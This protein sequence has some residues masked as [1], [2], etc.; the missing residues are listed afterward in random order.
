LVTLM[1]FITY[2]DITTPVYTMDWS[3]MF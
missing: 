2:Q 3:N 1:I